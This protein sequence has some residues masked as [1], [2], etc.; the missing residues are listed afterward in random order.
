[1]RQ[2]RVLVGTGVACLA[3]AAFVGWKIWKDMQN[4]RTAVVASQRAQI[5]SEQEA[6]TRAVTAFRDRY[7][8][9]PLISNNSSDMQRQF[10]K[11]F[12]RY[13]G[14]AAQDLAARGL[15]LDTLDEAE[16]LVF[17]IGGLREK[18]D[19]HKLVGFGENPRAPLDSS[20]AAGGLFEF[21]PA[22]LVD[23]DNDQ[24]LEYQTPQL[25]GTQGVYKL[26]IHTISSKVMVVVSGVLLDHDTL[27]DRPNGS[28]H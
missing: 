28:V 19:S 27:T 7:G 23:T 5:R 25:S 2:S 17:W 9:S 12:P 22:R 20:K 11:M 10:Q 13:T 16:M 14:D 8:I 21:D 1:M 26:G 18:P 15:R 3:V 4:V 6:L 24:W